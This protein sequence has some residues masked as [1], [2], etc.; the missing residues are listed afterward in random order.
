MNKKV[1]KSL[2]S[3]FTIIAYIFLFYL[4]S[5]LTR[6]KISAA[7][8]IPV[9]IFAVLYGLWGGIIAGVSS[10]PINFVLY[11]VFR[12][13]NL[14]DAFVNYGSGSI[15]GHFALIIAG[16]VVGY[17]RDLRGKLVVQKQESIRLSKA[18][19][20]AAEIIMTMDAD[21]TVQYVNPAT[22][23][24]FGFNADEVIGLN[25]F[26]TAQGTY[27]N[28]PETVFSAVKKGE[29]WNKTMQKKH[30]D[31]GTRLIDV[32]ISP[33]SD[34]AG[35]LTNLLLIGRDV[36]NETEMENR[37]RQSQKMESIGTLAGGIAHDFNN[38]LSVVIGFTELSINK[39]KDRPDVQKSLNMVLDASD[40]AKDLVS[41]ILT[42]SRSKPINKEQIEAAPIVKEVCKFMRSSLP[43]TIEIKQDIKAKNDC[44]MSDPIQFQQILM[45][46]C[47]NAGQAMQ[48]TGGVLEVILEETKL[49]EGD[50]LSY[51]SLKPGPYLK[52]SVKDTGPGISKENLERIFE[53]YFTTKKAGEGTGLGLAV[54]HGVVKN[55]GGDIKIY[56]E[57]GKGTVFHVLFPTTKEIKKDL[58]SEN[59]EFLPK[60]TESIMLVDDEELIVEI[61]SKILEQQGYR[62]TGFTNPEKA[63][64]MFNDSKNSYDLI[65]TDKTM[66][67][68]TGLELAA[69]IKKVRPD[70]PILL[71]TGFLD[72]DIDDKVQKAGITEYV[73]KP[74]NSRELAISV[75]KVL[76]KK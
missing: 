1:S 75:R 34:G 42:F 52:L 76:D 50:L 51:P 43:T 16:A 25:M 46:L 7:A 73:T 26:K 32:T 36:T 64:D 69:E 70:I 27:P 8:I 35:T 68:M 41:Q 6:D 23:N 5:N 4:L 19:E 54:V 58:S 11:M 10:I 15:I 22:T 44:I 13:E 24:L 33:I 74:L 9:I 2:I 62:I 53:P 29:S 59:S 3:I 47:T 57:L 14:N 63:L 55:Y 61:G 31:G 72:E 56:S 67:K 66:P 49:K 71:C 39:V 65:I 40:R 18:I 45:N 28:F 30:K 60:G 38:I 17:F 21:G 20:Q 37:L 12:E 48:E